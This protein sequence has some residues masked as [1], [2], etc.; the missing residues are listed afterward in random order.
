MR[1]H[2]FLT[3][4]GLWERADLWQPFRDFFPNAPEGSEGL[5]D[6]IM[7]ANQLTRKVEISAQASKLIYELILAAHRQAQNDFRSLLPD[8]LQ[9]FLCQGSGEDRYV[10]E[11]LNGMMGFAA[12]SAV[13]ISAFPNGDWQDTLRQMVLH[14]TNHVVRYAYG[15]PYT[16]LL[17][18]FIFE[19]MAE[20]YVAEKQGHL[21]AS[22]F[23]QSVPLPLLKE[24][25][26]KV[27]TEWFNPETKDIAAGEWMVG[28]V[29]HGIPQ[30]FGY[31]LGYALVRK[32]REFHGTSPW[33]EFIKT[34]SS[35]FS[36]IEL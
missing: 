13:L 1:I 26:P 16:S 28:S 24:L 18:Y 19:G 2:D 35:A 30:S 22:S 11:E 33:S 14:E 4:P 36:D 15:D 8:D 3:N 21:A 6:H 17:E 25:L 12:T 32:F 10:V 29:E 5:R 7:E 20:N 34:D 9:Y 27:R 23:V 31:A